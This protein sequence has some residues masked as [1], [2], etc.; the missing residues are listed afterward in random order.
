MTARPQLPYSRCTFLSERG[1]AQDCPLFHLCRCD[2]TSKFSQ[3][4]PTRRR[5]GLVGRALGVSLNL[6]VSQAATP[7]CRPICLDP[8]AWKSDLQRRRVD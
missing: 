1:L 8:C 6:R 2:H 4:P 3:E 7:T 5:A